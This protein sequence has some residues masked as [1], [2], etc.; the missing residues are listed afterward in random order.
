[1]RIQ[2]AKL[3]ARPV[4]IIKKQLNMKKITVILLSIVTVFIVLTVFK[5]MAFI[6]PEVE[7][8]AH[9]VVLALLFGFISFST[10]VL[11]YLVKSIIVETFKK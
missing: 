10:L 4:L 9:A 6:M 11:C 2:Y 7:T 1:M 8:F 3:V 5:T